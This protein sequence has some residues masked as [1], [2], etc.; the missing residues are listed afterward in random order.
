M[1]Q[2]QRRLRDLVPAMDYGLETLLG[3]L[4]V[5]ETESV[6]S[7]AVPLGGHPRLLVN[8]RFVERHCRSDEALW[9]LVMHELHHLLLGHTRLF[10]RVTPAHNLAMDAVINAMLCR[11]NPKP[12]WTALFRDLYR[13]DRFPELLLRPPE[14]F[15][16]PPHFAPGVRGEWRAALRHLYYEQSGTFGEVFDLLVR[17]TLSE[18]AAEEDS[19]SGPV[20]SADGEGAGARGPGGDPGDAEE[21]GAEPGD[22]PLGELGRRLLGNHDADTRGVEARDDPALFSAIRRI[23]ER[24]PQ[25]PDPR[26]GRSLDEFAR[27][28]QVRVAPP[29]RPHQVVRRALLAVARAGSVRG[30]RHRAAPC[31]VEQPHP[32]RDRRA[33]A[34]Q[35]AGH[36]PLL[37]RSPLEDPRGVRGVAPVDVYIDVSGSV[38]AWLPHVFTAVLSCHTLLEPRLWTFCTAVRPITAEELRLGR[39]HSTQGTV[40]AAFSSHLRER[41]STAA[42][43]ITD[44]YVGALPPDDVEACRRARLQVVLTPDGYRQDLA[45]A[46]AA[47]HQL[48]KP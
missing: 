31:I 26:I 16:G 32:G 48:E 14:G 23:V 19:P 21:A 2:L 36:L 7:A 15:P 28:L 38:L 20:P 10:E 42:V 27:D 13:A 24:W 12:A 22:G 43:V 39:Y 40:G 18:A 5:V 9:T 11:R 17:D 3:L 6:P 30:P 44:G 8:P 45:S 4:D 33:F 35:A 46:A 37:Y 25:P 41:R 47:F 1:S 29:A 34:L